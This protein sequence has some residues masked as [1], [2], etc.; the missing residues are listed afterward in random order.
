MPGAYPAASLAAYVKRDGDVFPSGDWSDEGYALAQ[1]SSCCAVRKSIGYYGYWAGT[2][3]KIID[4]YG[5]SDPFLSRL[6]VFDRE[7]WRIGHFERGLPAGY[8]ESV[9]DGANVIRDS[10]LHPYYEHIRLI[11]QSEK[12]FSLER[13]DAVVGWNI[14]R[15]NIYIQGM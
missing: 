15:F 12:L 5:L 4:R 9:R 8:I 1:S 2:E 3:K 13:I 10:R 14:G 7:K 6:P 11:T